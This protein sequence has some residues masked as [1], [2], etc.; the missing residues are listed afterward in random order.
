MVDIGTLFWHGLCQPYTVHA[1]DTGFANSIIKECFKNDAFKFKKISTCLILRDDVAKAPKGNE[2]I[3]EKWMGVTLC[4]AAL[5]VLCYG[6]AL[7]F[8]LQKKYMKNFCSYF[9]SQM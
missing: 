1:F 5:T 6:F 8:R 4:L 7:L 9:V 3:E 2:N